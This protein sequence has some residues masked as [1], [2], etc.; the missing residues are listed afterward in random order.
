MVII[1]EISIDLIIIA[2]KDLNGETF[3][4]LRY[5]SPII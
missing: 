5:L 4:D 1:I 2:S 3:N